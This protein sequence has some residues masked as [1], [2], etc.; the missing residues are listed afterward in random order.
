MMKIII[1]FALCLMVCSSALPFE[2]KSDKGEKGIIVDH[3]H[4]YKG[5]VIK[6][7]NYDSLWNEAMNFDDSPEGNN[8]LNNCLKN[9]G[10]LEHLKTLKNLEIEYNLQSLLND[11]SNYNVEQFFNNELKYKKISHTNDTLTS[12]T[13]LNGNIASTTNNEDY[14]PVDN[15]AF[16]YELFNYLLMSMPASINTETFPEIKYGTRPDDSLNYI[17]LKKEDTLMVV[18]GIDLSDN[19]IKKIEGIIIHDDSRMVFIN[20]FS[21]FKEYQ[22]FILPS[23]KIHVSMGLR[24]SEYTIISVKINH[25][26]DEN[27]FKVEKK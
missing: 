11:K 20:Y 17:Y 10:G 19:F 8:V 6:K 26:F 25:E 24:M 23:K 3:G 18:L 21:D 14:Y 9:Y 1:V 16:K 15:G 2:E 22:G 7:L 27:T 13:V 5:E 4:W 12:T